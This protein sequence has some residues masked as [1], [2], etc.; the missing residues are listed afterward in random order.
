MKKTISRLLTIFMLFAVCQLMVH[1][2]LDQATQKFADVLTKTVTDAGHTV[3]INTQIASEANL[4]TTVVNAFSSKLVDLIMAN[5]TPALLHAANMTTKT[6]ALGTSVSN[7][8]DTFTD[9]I[10]ANVSGPSDVVPFNE[11]VTMMIDSL[12]LAAGDVVGVLYCTNESNSLIQYEAVKTLF[13][14]TDIVV[15]A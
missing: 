14:E 5:A 2:S 3:D 11:R 7:Y 1:I 8:A 4:Y 9:D 15:K 13:E 6:L 12:G 10:P